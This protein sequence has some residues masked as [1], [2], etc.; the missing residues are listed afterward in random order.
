MLENGHGITVCH[1]KKLK[2]KNQSITK[3]IFEKIRV[4]FHTMEVQVGKEGHRPAC[5]KVESEFKEM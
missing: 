1:S 4:E 2:D 5:V 3:E